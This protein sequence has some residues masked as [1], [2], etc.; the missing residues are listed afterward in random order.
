MI[1]RILQSPS[2]KGNIA[3]VTA[4]ATV[5]EATAFVFSS[6][7]F[8]RTFSLQ[9]ADRELSI[10]IKQP[11]TYVTPLKLALVSFQNTPEKDEHEDEEVE[12]GEDG[13]EVEEIEEVEEDEE[14]EE[15][16]GSHGRN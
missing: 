13:E 10:L 6:Y 5:T 14:D 9:K 15:D 2:V 7:L 4:M 1:H 16:E 12:D 3:I 11:P 8:S